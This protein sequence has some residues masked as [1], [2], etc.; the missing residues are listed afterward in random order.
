MKQGL[1]LRWEFL[2]I[3]I[4]RSSSTQT[5]KKVIPFHDSHG[6]S[7][8]RVE[9]KSWSF[10]ASR[11]VAITCTPHSRLIEREDY[12]LGND[13]AT[14]I[15]RATIIYSL[16]TTC[17]TSRFPQRAS[18]TTLNAFSSTLPSTMCTANSTRKSVRAAKKSGSNI[19]MESF[20]WSSSGSA[21]K[22]S[23]PRSSR[24]Q[25]WPRLFFSVNRTGFM[26]RRPTAG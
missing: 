18:S 7:P 21:M 20:L 23:W 5:R 22:R 19:N 25:T 14:T 10:R 13:R 1:G 9:E 11:L 24:K 12:I 2:V 17:S 8:N 3:K 16:L 4:E 6:H 15:Y 26:K